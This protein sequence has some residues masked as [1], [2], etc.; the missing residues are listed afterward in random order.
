MTFHTNWHHFFQKVSF[1]PKADIN[2]PHQ[3]STKRVAV[4]R[5]VC[6]R[7]LCALHLD[8]QNIIC[9]WA[10]LALTNFKLNFLA[11]INRRVLVTAFNF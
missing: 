10:F 5:S 3:R 1:R 2:A 8:R 4:W 7:L 9:T 6:M 11:V